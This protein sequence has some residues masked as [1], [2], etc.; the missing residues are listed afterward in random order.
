MK[1]G[2]ALVAAA[3]LAFTAP[4]SAVPVTWNTSCPQISVADD[5]ITSTD[6]D[7]DL[8]LAPNVHSNSGLDI[9]NNYNQ[10]EFDTADGTYNGTIACTV[11]SNGVSVPAGR[12]IQMAV[13]TPSSGK[14][15]HTYTLA[16]LTVTVPF[17][18][19]AS[20][21]LTMGQRLTGSGDSTADVILIVPNQ[22]T[23]IVLRMP[24]LPA[25]TAASG[26]GET[27]ATL[28]GTV[29]PRNLG[30]T[31]HFEWGPAGGPLSNVTPDQAIPAGGAP[32][33][34]SAAIGGLQSGR[35]YTYRLVASNS[36]GTADPVATRDFTTAVPPPPPAP[37]APP[38][39]A[40]PKVVV[41]VT[42]RVI[43]LPSTKRCLSRRNFPMRV[44]MPAGVTARS[45]RISIN[46]KVKKT[47]TGA[48][49]AKQIDLRGLPAGKVKVKVAVTTTD[50][51]TVTDTRTYRT[52]AKK[53]RR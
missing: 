5:E 39:P 4:A 46:G 23:D 12:D 9:A 26:V 51:R 3:A 37:P 50:G 38:P 32:V 31:V 20:V 17:S 28:T 6:P 45:A 1:L 8:D 35:G 48:G 52:C 47:V 22:F 49:L 40:P 16:P 2:A 41:P 53:K 30:A 44:R 19:G 29:D 33:N 25:T 15:R 7:L 10:V 43:S 21:V 11:T 14:K 13:T 27:A 34:V 18:G 36:V 24:P 42:K